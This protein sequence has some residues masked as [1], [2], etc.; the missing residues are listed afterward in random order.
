[1]MMI[2]CAHKGAF[3]YYIA[4]SGDEI[5]CALPDAMKAICRCSFLT[6]LRVC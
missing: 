2:G 1:M 6:G 3:G 5:V 4:I